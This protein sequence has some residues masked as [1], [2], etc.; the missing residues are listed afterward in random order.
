MQ[1]VDLGSVQR[2]AHE[3]QS[4]VRLLPDRLQR[5]LAG[6]EARAPRGVVPD[7]RRA[8]S[9]DS[10][11]DQADRSGPMAVVLASCCFRPAVSRR[12]DS[13]S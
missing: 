11:A 1:R 3:E 13:A 10:W 4:V 6:T 5:Q 12:A 9:A 2:A 7:A 8:G